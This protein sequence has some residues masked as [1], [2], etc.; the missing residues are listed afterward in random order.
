MKEVEV[1]KVA[2]DLEFKT[3][4][5]LLKEKKGN[6]KLPI[7]MGLPEARAIVLAM[8]DLSSSSSSTVDLIKSL[9]KKFKSCVDKVIIN[10]LKNDT[11]YAKIFLKMDEEIL[12]V[13]ARPSDAIALALKFKAPIYIDEDRIAAREKP[14]DEREV[15]E[16]K[17]KLKDIKPEDFSF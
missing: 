7:W 4:V 6:K 8:K 14:I 13:D 9:I 2:L 12:D 10:E 3:P 5:V 16:F 11:Y 17:E 1:I 15:S